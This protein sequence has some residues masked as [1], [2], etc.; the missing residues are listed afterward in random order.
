MLFLSSTRLDTAAGKKTI[1]S[2]YLHIAF[3]IGFILLGCAVSLQLYVS[4]KS[5]QSAQALEKQS[6]RL[7]QINIL[8]LALANGDTIIDSHLL[9]A[10]EKSI[11]RWKKQFT[12]ISASLAELKSARWD[13]NTD[14]QI[15]LLEQDLLALNRHTLKL[16]S[17]RLNISRQY[18]AI[19]HAHTRMLPAHRRFL[20]A[21]DKALTELEADHHNT[22]NDAFHRD[23]SLAR[24][25][26]LQAVGHFR[27]Y[28]VIRLSSVA[29]GRDSR[30]Q[31]TNSEAYQDAVDKLVRKMLSQ[32]RLPKHSRHTGIDLESSLREM[33]AAAGKWRRYY[34][35]VKKLDSD[36]YW[37]RDQIIRA[38]RLQPLK[39]RIDRRLQYLVTEIDKLSKSSLASVSRTATEII[40][41][42]WILTAFGLLTIVVAYRYFDSRVLQPVAKITQALNAEAVGEHTDRLPAANFAETQSLVNAFSFM[43]NQ[44]RVRESMLEHQALHDTLTQLPNRALLENS[45]ER[46]IRQAG[47]KSTLAVLVLDLNEF[48]EVNDSLGHHTG[49]LVLEQA[50]TRIK[51]LLTP[52]DIVAR[53]GGDE[54][55]VL[56]P[57]AD[58]KEAVLTAEKIARTISNAY[59]VAGHSLHIG[60]SIGIAL[61]P[62]HAHDTSSLLK[63]ADVAMYIAKRKRRPCYVYHSDS[64]GSGPIE[65][66][67]PVTGLHNT[68]DTDRLQLL[69]QPIIDLHT[70]TLLGAEALLCWKQ[71]QYADASADEIITMAEHHGCARELVHWVIINA[72]Q[73]VHGDRNDDRGFYVSVDV[74]TVNLKQPGF[75]ALV[76]S[77]LQQTGT[78]PAQLVLEIPESAVASTNRR[79]IENLQELHRLGVRLTVDDFGAGLSSAAVLKR[80]PVS[81]VKINGTFVDRML[82]IEDDAVVV[83][84]MI[85]LA[86]NIGLPVIVSGISNQDT[87]ALVQIMGGDGVQGD[88]LYRPMTLNE[89][90]QHADRHTRRAEQADPSPASHSF[91]TGAQ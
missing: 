21:A 79:V 30:V 88:C 13:K 2:R 63:A 24:S 4:V 10:S 42:L 69:Y 20:N 65:D 29:P 57:H 72:L 50:A 12:L 38:N 75:G 36:R 28:L 19:Y 67:C 3:L 90:Q 71:Q 8:Q 64:N 81:S 70:N 77:A 6:S 46:L 86:H 37:R 7:Q 14:R 9:K 40:S 16:I 80:A 54:F 41:T 84:S 23:L 73:A 74:S 34:R 53:L 61:Y 59:I 22:A 76:R 44:I 35:Q 55:A 78:R 52:D 27:M 91:T 58:R 43:R 45:I 31:L 89:L 32:S 17:L 25:Y 15:R 49:D 60:A 62:K 26:W 85:K 47:D 82:D 56:L 68:I 48:K 39:I 1:R 5:R 18:P 33:A 51:K 66:N 11:D 83:C 87:L